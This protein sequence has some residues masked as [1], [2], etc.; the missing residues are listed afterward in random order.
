[1]LLSAR[2]ARG[3]PRPREPDMGG[4]NDRSPLEYGWRN[5]DESRSEGKGHR[6]APSKPS[7]RP[8]YVC[9]PSAAIQGGGR[10]DG[11]SI[12]MIGDSESLVH[13][14]EIPAAMR[15][16]SPMPRRRVHHSR[17]A[18]VFPEDLLQHLELFKEASGL[19][20]AE[21]GPPPRDLSRYRKV[22]PSPSPRLWILPWQ[23]P[24]ACPGSVLRW[25]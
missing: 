19:S 4:G 7:G 23:A 12:A 18:Y 22:P 21:L 14:M 6:P 16:T 1:M 20:W 24:P 5:D 11:G 15:V 25:L 2:E 8:S 9:R 13:R 17:K 10:I 3:D